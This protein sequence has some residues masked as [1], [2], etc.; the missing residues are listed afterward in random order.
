MDRSEIDASAPARMQADGQ[1]PWESIDPNEPATALAEPPAPRRKRRGKA[2]RLPIHLTAP[3][4]SQSAPSAEWDAAAGAPRAIHRSLPISE[5]HLIEAAFGFDEPPTEA[6]RPAAPRPVAPE[7]VATDSVAVEA[8]VAEPVTAEPIAA[9]PVAAEPVAATAAQATPIADDLDQTPWMIDDPQTPAADEALVDEPADEIVA[10]HVEAATPDIHAPIEQRDE[11]AATEILLTAPPHVGESI[12]ERAAEPA[13][14]ESLPSAVTASETSATANAA[15]SFE[16]G[17]FTQNI[18]ASI[19]TLEPIATTVDAEPLAK[20]PTVDWSPADSSLV[21][22]S[23]VDE[24]IYDVVCEVEPSQTENRVD[25]AQT[26]SASD[27]VAETVLE[28]PAYDVVCETE[29]ADAP[30]ALVDAEDDEAIFDV[31]CEV[32]PSTDESSTLPAS[33][34]PIAQS[35]S[36]VNPPLEEPIQQYRFP[37]PVAEP[38]PPAVTR[39]VASVTVP[40]AASENI[41]VGEA[42]GLTAKP[43]AEAP[44]ASMPAAYPWY[45]DFDH[46]ATHAWTS[47]GDLP[48]LGNLTVSATEAAVVAPA[49]ESANVDPASTATAPAPAAPPEPA[50]A[51]SAPAAPDEAPPQV[52]VT[53]ALTDALVTAVSEMATAAASFR[54]TEADLQLE[55]RLAEEARMEVVADLAPAGPTTGGGWTIPL[56][57]VGLGLIACC[58]IIPQAETNRQLFHEQQALSADLDRLQKQVSVNDEFLKNVLDNPTLAERLASR[59]LKT[60]RKGQKVLAMKEGNDNADMSPFTLVDLPPAAPTPPYRAKRGTIADLCNNARS[61]LYLLGMALAMVAIG[62]VMDSRPRDAA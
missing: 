2:P 10:G 37:D 41:A 58:V 6:P 44:A 13:P 45:A 19:F 5:E 27:A 4:A 18:T 40:I 24:E 56:M 60:I 22:S 29:S 57:C 1:T 39:V 23:P 26:A 50:T 32:E 54:L 30:M 42:D 62:L 52:K 12:A 55:A 8:I 35:A 34:E 11:S 53:F 49:A 3:V 15:P 61:R 48:L 7:T 20:T 14:A 25:E 16:P 46:A 36:S 9:E 21:E 43:A 59:Q 31:V 33:P 38:P 28:E 51:A 17:P 47:L